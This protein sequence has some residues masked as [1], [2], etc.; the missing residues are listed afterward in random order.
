M[1]ETPKD[2][3]SI[4]LAALDIQSP[5]ERAAFVARSCEGDDPLRKRVDDLL[6]AYGESGGPLDKMAA[7]IAPTQLGE[8][9]R[10]QVG[11]TIGSYKLME[12][13][14]EG[15]F[16][17]VFVAEQQQPIRRKVALKIIKPG[18]DTRD[19]IARFEAERQA[20]A[21][22]DHPNIAR[23][24]DA[25]TTESGRPYFVMEL[26]R[27]IPITEY[28]DQT[29][30]TPRERLELFVPVCNAIQHAHL[31]G[32]IHRDVKPSNVLITLHDDRPVV[33]VI[34]FG[35]AKALHQQLT[36]RTIYTRYAQMIGTPLYMSPEQAQMSG[37]DI[38]T[39][40]DIYSLGVLL[41]ELLTGSTPFNKERLAK[42][43]YDELLKI[44]REEEPPK[45]SVR[46][47]QST[48]TLPSI[49][50]QR[51]TE[52]AKLSKMFSGDLDW[53]AMKALEKDRTRR[54]ETAN[55]FAADVLRYLNDEPVEASPPSASYR[56]RKFARKHRKPVIAVASLGAVLVLGIAGTTWGLI[57]AKEAERAAIVAEASERAQRV[58]AEEER[59]RALA[60]EGKERQQRRSAERQF[61]NGLLRPIGFGDGND[62]GGFGIGK[63]KG[64]GVTMNAA[65]LRSFVDWAAAKD[66]RLKLR[67]LE[68]AL[69]NPEMALR[70]ARRAEQVIQSAVGLSPRRRAQAIKLVSARQRDL[71]ADPR[72]RVSAC[73]LAL[74]LGTPDLPAWAESCNYLNTKQSDRFTEFVHFA[75]SRTDPHQVA[76]L[77]L[78]PLLRLLETSTDQGVVD[79]SCRALL[80]MSSRLDVAHS[81]RAADDLVNIIQKKPEW[82]WP[83]FGSSGGFS[84]GSPQSS[85]FKLIKV[86]ANQLDAKAASRT[87][88]SLIAALD[89]LRDHH[90]AG[91]RYP[92]HRLESTL[93]GLNLLKSRLQAAQ[94][95]HIAQSLSDLTQKPAGIQDTVVSHALA[96]ILPLLQEKQVAKIADRLIAMPTAELAL[97]QLEAIAPRIQPEHAAR[98]WDVVMNVPQSRAE[99]F[100]ELIEVSVEPAL[101]ALAVRL[102]TFQ[103][104]KVANELISFL[105]KP[106]GTR[107][108]NRVVIA[109][110]AISPRLEQAQVKRASEA[111][112]PMLRKF[113]NDPLGLP[114]QNALVKLA[115]RLQPVQ[116]K[117]AWDA[118]A[119]TYFV[120]GI[121]DDGDSAAEGLVSL[122]PR[123]GSED[124]DQAGNT[125]IAILDT[126]T[127]DNMKVFRATRGL[128]EL[129]PRLK[130]SQAERAMRALIAASGRVNFDPYTGR[131]ISA[132]A[133][134]FDQ[135]QIAA[136]ARLGFADQPLKFAALLGRLDRDQTSAV[137]DDIIAKLKTA[138]DTES[139][140]L[141]DACTQIRVLA[142]RLDRGQITRAW[143]ALTAAA[144]RDPRPSPWGTDPRLG[145]WGALAALAPCLE[146]GPRDTQSTTLTAL[147]LDYSCCDSDVLETP[148]RFVRYISSPRS[149]A[150]L[151]SHPGCVGSR[152]EALLQRFDELVFY[153]GRPVFLKPEKS[154]ET[155]VASQDPMPPRRFH[156]LH[157][158]VAWIQQNWP[159][160]DLEMN[161]PATW[162]GSR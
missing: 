158:A 89:E 78:D 52:P 57:R 96:E 4:F 136:I 157:D 5:G 50:A 147:L 36:D 86:L 49:A 67:V 102:H 46:L 132:L 127:H 123:L 72:I 155:P 137:A 152:R 98:A 73:W 74:E 79:E 28:C 148:E 142:P 113:S 107:T 110:I 71:S 13:I 143:A 141:R 115:S 35:V 32:I 117:R 27:G 75:S 135:T 21:L 76:Q 18:M 43:A 82:I 29:Q 159:D 131:A 126:A 69:E 39:R 122:A 88:E 103:A 26:V 118:V 108:L 38:D 161:C 94:A 33:K 150:K 58:T 90:S 93:E 12:Q 106:S 62:R 111:L 112:I 80:A 40:S 15:G 129:A 151:L 10:E 6:R 17:L 125:L 7:A 41:Y 9:I 156:N 1:S 2:A 91:I 63:R 47:S 130:P 99:P 105:E 120:Q 64:Y 95:A 48:D 56:L 42:A 85:P 145:V 54:Y 84:G 97:E 30:L 119:T 83:T 61:A 121:A 37:L 139:A 20:L 114:I 14:G 51:K 146:S 100:G 19:V 24:L 138:T 101:A 104:E 81:G 162:R 25:G 133:R 59:A 149:L 116:A 92:L 109:L 65:E 11:S 140:A 23:V 128:E 60:A 77:S 16:G 87:T 66:S 124:V 154:E 134:Q 55:A 34:D 70:V 44:I 31:K 3:K 53:I 22:M 8:P 45:P 160:F 68:I 144:E 153:D